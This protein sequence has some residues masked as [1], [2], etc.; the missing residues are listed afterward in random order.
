MKRI[1]LILISLF[2][3]I[4][5][6]ICQENANSGVRILFHGMVLDS[7]TLSP[8]PN[9][10]ILINRE[11]STVSSSNGN[12]AF[13]VNRNDT[14]LFKH[15]GYKPTFMF[16]A[17][18]LTGQEFIT[19][20]YLNSD[21]LEIGEVIILPRFKDIKS[22]VLNAKTK[23]SPQLENARYNVAMSAYQGRTT[24]G[25]LGDPES[26]YRVLHQRQKINAFERGTIPSDRIVGIS[27]FLFL[28]AAYL[29]IHGSPEKPPAFD[30]ELTDQEM[31]LIREKYLESLKQRR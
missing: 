3:L 24:Q 12:F 31:E 26:N 8:V 4:N 5:S 13:Y 10:Q 2:F 23:T 29:L 17:D 19:G 7:K 9:S 22:E 11:F 16:V 14:V 1:L 6:G 20:V 21:T 15:L 18:T 28:P 27:P 30:Q 25:E